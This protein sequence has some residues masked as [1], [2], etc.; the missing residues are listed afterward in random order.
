[1]PYFRKI[2]IA[3]REM[4]NPRKKNIYEIRT[5]LQKKRKKKKK[6]IQENGKQAPR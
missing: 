1:M 2:L 3:L 6:K 4:N 5:P